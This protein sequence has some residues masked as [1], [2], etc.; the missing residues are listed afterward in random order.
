MIGAV[1]AGGVVVEIGA[2]CGGSS[3]YG[4][5]TG[6]GKVPSSNA[7]ARLASHRVLPIRLYKPTLH[8]TSQV[9]DVKYKPSKH[10]LGVSINRR[11]K[12]GREWCCVCVCLLKGRYAW[13][14]VGMLR[15]AM[16]YRL[17]DYL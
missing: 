3:R 1:G 16:P 5:W 14:N 12:E 4:S 11:F 2:V 8:Q 13:M 7:S 10:R 9:I 6:D 15:F 17:T